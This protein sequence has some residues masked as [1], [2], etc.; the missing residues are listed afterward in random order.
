MS[1]PLIVNCTH[2]LAVGCGNISVRGKTLDERVAVGKPW[3]RY[4]MAV[5]G[6]ET[7]TGTAGDLTAYQLRNPSSSLP[8]GVAGASAHSSQKPKEEALK[9][10]EHR[11]MKNRKSASESRI[12]KKEFMHN[13]QDRLAA[14]ETEN[15]KLRARLQLFNNT[16]PD[17]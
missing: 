10:R 1:M 4:S 17:V 6:D 15:A 8:Q 11:L 3:S 9:K 12:R 5:T 7:E 16:C 14:L 2:S 13:L